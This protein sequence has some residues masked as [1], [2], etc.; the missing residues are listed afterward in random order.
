[1]LTYA[2]VCGNRSA[3][4]LKIVEKAPEIA[5]FRLSGEAFEVFA[6]VLAYVSIRQHTSAYVSIR[7]H[8]SAYASIRGI[9][10]VRTGTGQATKACGLK[11]LKHAALSYATKAC[12]LK[13]L[14]HAALSRLLLFSRLIR[15]GSGQAGPALLRL[16]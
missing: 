4:R 16:Y 10:G 12:G 8:T 1:M 11:L 5:L 6:Q 3:Y 7:Q 2:D 13:L 15:T 14:K 9:R